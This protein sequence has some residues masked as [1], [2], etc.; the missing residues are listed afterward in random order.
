MEDLVFRMGGTEYRVTG[1]VVEVSRGSFTCGEIIIR[2]AGD[3]E[4]R[5]LHSDPHFDAPEGRHVHGTRCV[6]KCPRCLNP[7]TKKCECKGCTC[8]IH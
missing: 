5:Q 3:V 8:G 6:C 4:T 2:V 7:V 1:D